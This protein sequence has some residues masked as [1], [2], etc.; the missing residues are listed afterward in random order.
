ME[1]IIAAALSVIGT[2]VAAS[3]TAWAAVNKARVEAE[4]QMQLV[5][6]RMDETEKKISHIGNILDRLTR[7]ETQ[8]GIK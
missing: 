6:Y 8:A 7:L 5:L 1:V 4:K 3:I 2:A